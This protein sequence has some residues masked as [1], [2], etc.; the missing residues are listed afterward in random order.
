MIG[1]W[2]WHRI[3]EAQRTIILIAFLGTYK[4]DETQILFLF[5]VPR[6]IGSNFGKWKQLIQ[7]PRLFCCES[8]TW[9]KSVVT[10]CRVDFSEPW[11]DGQKIEELLP[12]LS[13]RSK[14]QLSNPKNTP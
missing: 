3:C 7:G 2:M 14:S 11:D 1:P 12:C 5:S 4:R 10:K 13:H 9:T 8:A 6:S